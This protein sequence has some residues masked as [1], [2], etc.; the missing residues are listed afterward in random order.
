[1]KFAG[2]LEARLASGVALLNSWSFGAAAS[3]EGLYYYMD[4]C[5]DYLSRVRIRSMYRLC[6]VSRELDLRNLGERA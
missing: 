1:M 2:D 4:S 3:I 5:P 6:I